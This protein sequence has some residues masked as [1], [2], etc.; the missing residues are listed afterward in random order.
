MAPVA[1][2]GEGGQALAAGIDNRRGSDA[3][4]LVQGVPESPAFIWGQ[5]PKVLNVP[6]QDQ[7]GG[8][9][10]PPNAQPGESQVKGLGRIRV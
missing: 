2:L 5:L 6:A 9:V 4:K 3:L 8:F 10:M 1:K 7:A